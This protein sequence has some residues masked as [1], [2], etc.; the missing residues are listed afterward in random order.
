MYIHNMSEKI[1]NFN[2]IRKNLSDEKI[3]EIKYFYNII[4]KKFGVVRNHFNITKECI[5]LQ[6]LGSGG[7]VVIG[8]ISGGTTLNPIILGAI[9]GAGVLLQTYATAKSMIGN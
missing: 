5:Y 2:H 9:S 7:L 6:N 8:T 4:T 3:K 1:F